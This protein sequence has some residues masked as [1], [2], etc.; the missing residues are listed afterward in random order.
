MKQQYIRHIP[1][2]L[3]ILHLFSCSNFTDST[4]VEIVK[5][6]QEE[7]IRINQQLVQK[8]KKDIESFVK[9]K[10]WDMLISDSG[11]W[12]MTINE[13]DG[14][15]VKTNQ[16]VKIN[17][18]VLLLDGTKLYSSE[19][20]GPKSFTVGSGYVEKGLEEGILLMRKG[21]KMRFIMPPHLAHGLI[22]DGEKIPARATLIYE[23]ELLSKQ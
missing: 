3:I 8:D 23:V 14:E 5:P 2:I 12:Y 16:S 10:L 18:K 22:G 6:T 19:A 7:L 1:L 15:I 13:G 4:N 11:L 20:T 9:L 17:Y 21:T